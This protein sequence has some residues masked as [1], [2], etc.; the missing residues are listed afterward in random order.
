MSPDL[1]GLH[2]VTAIAGDPQSNLDF[3][4]GVLGMRLVKR[5]VNFDD[6]AS[7]H[8]YYGDALGRPGSLL[9]FFAWPGAPRGRTGTGEPTA[10]ALAVPEGALAYWRARLEAAGVSPGA[11]E[12]RFGEA[13]IAFADPDG[14]SIELVEDPGAQARAGWPDGPVPRERA[15]RGLHGVTLESPRLEGSAA[16]LTG[17]LGF[18]AA[19]REQ[20]RWRFRSVAGESGLRVDLVD[21]P[22]VPRG[23]LGAG[24]IH[25]VA[26][27]AADDAAQRAWREIL[28]GAG[29]HATDVRERVYF[30]SIY[31]HEPGGVLY[32]IATDAPGFTVDEAETELGS[33]LRLPPWLEGSRGPLEA[34]LPALRPPV[35]APAGRGGAA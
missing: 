28:A 19:G 13:Q 20:D 16:L 22:E 17:T 25:H 5:T 21:R 7:Y 18:A 29:L 30:R 15:I 8:L 9:T 32:E 2:H 34:A 6:P 31:F 11:V 35:T 14:M 27:R 26:W 23:R 33:T 12:R 1:N 24:I 4:A 10:V 3:Y